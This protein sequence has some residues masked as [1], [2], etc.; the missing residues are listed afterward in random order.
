MM[1]LKKNAPVLISPSLLSA[2]PLNVADSIR[3]LDGKWDWLH[4]DIMDGHFVPNLT[5]G[6]GFVSALHR[7]FSSAFL[8]VHLM[9]DTPEDF[10]EPFAQAGATLLTVHVEG[11]IH[12]HR[13]LERIRALGCYAGVTLNPATPVEWLYPILSMVDLVLVMSV[14]PGFGGQS[15]IPQVLQK[16]EALHRWRSVHRADFLIEMDGGINADNANAAVRSGCDV[17]VAGNAVFAQ[18]NPAEAL[19]KIR[20]N[21]EG[22]GR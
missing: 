19:M 13:L 5:F 12:L 9:V 6:P 11:N 16:V 15:F 18:P 4:V 14:N 22:D 2:D 10:I 8:D 21:A 1:P 17:L 20:H 3:S 7:G